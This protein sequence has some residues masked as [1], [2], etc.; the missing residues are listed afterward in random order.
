MAKLEVFEL[1]RIVTLVSEGL[2]DL[3]AHPLN[4]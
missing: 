1:E 2:D 3:I 4:L